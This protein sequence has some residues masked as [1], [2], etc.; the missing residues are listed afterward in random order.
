MK[1]EIKVTKGFTRQAK[2]LLKKYHS[3]REELLALQLVL[4]TEPTTGAHISEDI[5]KIRLAVKS[6]GKGKSGG[7]RV[8][9]FLQTILLADIEAES[10]GVES[11][12]VDD[13][14]T[15]ITIN[16]IAIYDKSDTSSISEQEIRDLIADIDFSEE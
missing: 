1:V 2:P 15:F 4:M 9:T 10:V 13:E 16:L 3:L 8:I 5:Y 14:G 7:L 6:K 12:E 11:K